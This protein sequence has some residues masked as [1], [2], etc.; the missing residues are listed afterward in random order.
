MSAQASVNGRFVWY[1]LMTTDPA[2]AAAY[3]QAVV[4]WTA[5]PGQ[6]PGIDY[7]L[8][9]SPHGYAGGLM[10]LPPEAA[11]KGAPPFWA[12]Y[13]GVDDLDAAIAR[14]GAAGGRLQEAPMAVEGVGRFACLADPQGAVFMLMEPAAGSSDESMPQ[15]TDGHVAWH[16]LYTH[17]HREAFAF[18]SQQFGWT[19][20]EL[21]DLGPMGRYQ[22]FEIDGVPAGGMMDAPPGLPMPCWGYYVQV[23]DLHAAAAR[24]SAHGGRVLQGPMQVPGGSFVVN[25]VDPQGAAFSL[26]GPG[27]SA[28]MAT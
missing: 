5:S 2:A 23:P 17:G 19:A 7:T 18:Y 16:E 27:G 1:E 3:Y 25:A 20:G 4:G 11:A 6:V 28:G 22:L 9:S 21:L 10:A 12:G 26:V 8:L 24:V 14:I 15:M 13:I